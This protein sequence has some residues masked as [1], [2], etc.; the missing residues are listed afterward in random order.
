MNVGDVVLHS[1]EPLD[2][3]AQVFSFLLGDDMQITRLAM[4]LVASLKGAN[5]LMTQIRPRRNGVTSKCI[6][7]DI[8]LGLS[9]NG[10]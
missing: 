1:A 2:V 4:S 6:N 8:T 5:K 9:A 7:H 10:K 3:L